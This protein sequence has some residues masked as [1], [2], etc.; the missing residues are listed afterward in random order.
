MKKRLFSLALALTICLGVSIPATAEENAKT[1]ALDSVEITNVLYYGSEVDMAASGFPGVL[2]ICRAPAEIKALEISDY[3][4]A[5]TEE[6]YWEDTAARLQIQ[7]AKKIPFY[8]LEPVF[9]KGA[10]YVIEEPGTYIVGITIPYHDPE[11]ENGGSAPYSYRITVLGKNEPAPS[12]DPF[13]RFSDVPASSP[14]ADGVK[15]AVKSQITKGKTETAFGPNDVC[16][17]AH[18]L[19]FLWRANGESNNSSGS[20]REAVLAWAKARGIIK[21]GQELD[22]PC[23]RAMAVEFMWRDSD[24][25]ESYE[26]ASFQDVAANAAYKQAVDWA[27]EA[28]ITA[29]TGDGSTFSP[30]NVCTRGQ[31]VTFLFRQ[32]YDGSF[33]NE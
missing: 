23:T 1:V 21:D 2:V 19:T 15:W 25:P 29:G 13:N 17:V 18:I 5:Q 9:D 12:G 6:G 31:I 33:L 27:V 20:E 11:T 3:F 24:C 32:H 16:T 26:A 14:Y 10:K 30:N 7:N 8:D 22:I 4:V 28:E